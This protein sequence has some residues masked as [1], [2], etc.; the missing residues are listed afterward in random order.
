[1]NCLNVYSAFG[2]I[3]S[4]SLPSCVAEKF[5]LM[6]EIVFILVMYCF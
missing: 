3:A 4:S 1:M 5:S 2:I 6:V